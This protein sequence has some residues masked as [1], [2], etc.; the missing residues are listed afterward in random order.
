M[1]RQRTSGGPTTAADTVK[2]RLL[3]LGGE[4]RGQR[5]GQRGQQ[6]EAAVHGGMVGLQPMA[7][8]TFCRP[9]CVR[10]VWGMVSSPDDRASQRRDRDGHPPQDGCWSSAEQSSAEDCESVRAPVH[11]ARHVISQ[12]LTLSAR[13]THGRGGPCGCIRAA[14][15]CGWRCRADP[16][17]HGRTRGS[18]RWPVRRS[19]SVTAAG[20]TEAMMVAR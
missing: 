5:T 6:E 20:R 18:G 11:C 14:T 9:I 4:R 10:V 12:S 19:A 17:T 1:P 15:Q 7:S 2:L 16:Q 8:A 3:R 13:L